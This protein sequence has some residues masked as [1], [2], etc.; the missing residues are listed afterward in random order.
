MS[1]PAP[2]GQHTTF[3]RVDCALPYSP[4]TL[5]KKYRLKESQLPRMQVAD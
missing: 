2:L 5:L 4:Q 1:Q 3:S